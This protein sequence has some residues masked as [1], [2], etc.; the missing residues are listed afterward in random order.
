MSV[1]YFVGP[2]QPRLSALFKKPP[3]AQTKEL[4]LKV[5]ALHVVIEN[6]ATNSVQLWQVWPDENS[7]H[8]KHVVQDV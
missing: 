5:P 4:V 1:M 7:M 8:A 2:N 6:Y 3:S